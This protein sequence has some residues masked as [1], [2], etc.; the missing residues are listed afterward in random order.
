[1]LIRSVDIESGISGDGT[2]SCTFDMTKEDHKKLHEFARSHYSYLGYN[3]IRRIC[4][5]SLP[6][7]LGGSNVM[8]QPKK[9]IFNG[10][11][12]IVIWKDGT[13]TVVKRSENDES[14]WRIAIVWCIMKKIFGSYTNA[15]KYIK[16]FSRLA[17]YGEEKED[18][19]DEKKE[20]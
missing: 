9:V 10:D 15:D 5:D 11:A 17:F 8:P 18:N 7:L 2:L 14:D 4:Q 6:F 3:D 13:K 20:N 12:T 1:M 16:Q 19:K